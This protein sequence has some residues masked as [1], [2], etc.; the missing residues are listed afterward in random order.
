MTLSSTSQDQVKACCSESTCTRIP[1]VAG[2]NADTQVPPWT[3]MNQSLWE[4]VLGTCISDQ[5]S[6][7]F[8]C[9]F[10]ADTRIQ[11]TDQP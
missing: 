8:S 2:S 9:M 10:L 11:K 4:Q 5:L 3:Q 7:V 6:K 1:Q